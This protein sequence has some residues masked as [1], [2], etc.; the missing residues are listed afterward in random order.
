MFVS[1]S[2]QREDGPPFTA[3]VGRCFCECVLGH[4]KSI[5]PPY[6]PQGNSVVK[7]YMRS[8]KKGVAALV[9]EDA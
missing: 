3:N 2:M 7:S 9:N 4:K 1:T 8:L 6:H 5:V